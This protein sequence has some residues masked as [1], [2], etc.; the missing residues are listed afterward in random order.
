MA[1]VKSGIREVNGMF[2]K[3]KNTEVL[4]G[5]LKTY[6]NQFDEMTATEIVDHALRV[7]INH[8]NVKIVTFLLREYYDSGKYNADV[9]RKD[10]TT[11][12]T[13]LHLA[14]VGGCHYKLYRKT[15]KIVKLLLETKDIQVNAKDFRG[16]TALYHAIAT[17]WHISLP[18]VKTLLKGGGGTIDVDTETFVKAVTKQSR[19]I[20]N[21]KNKIVDNGP[22]R[23]LEALMSANNAGIDILREQLSTIVAN[24][25]NDEGVAAMLRYCI[26]NY[27]CVSFPRWVD[28]VE[29]MMCFVGVTIALDEKLT[30]M[31]CW[32]FANM[33][34]LCFGLPVLVTVGFALLANY[35]EI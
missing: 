28:T 7:A 24:A 25:I 31:K 21:K 8:R 11:G 34:G 23:L 30:L 3:I 1:N 10:K 2:E 19:Y 16:K 29:K 27:K 6:L 22:L 18:M 12:A 14:V 5:K 17:S 20:R 13:P 15:I 4:Q 33:L 32:A 26:V 35:F 9:N